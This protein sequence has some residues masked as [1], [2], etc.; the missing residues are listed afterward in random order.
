MKLTDLEETR[1]INMP[2]TSLTDVALSRIGRI[3]E[4]LVLAESCIKARGYDR[5]VEAYMEQTIREAQEIIAYAGSEGAI[6]F[7]SKREQQR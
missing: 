1:T 7:A 5:A 4:N 6:E 2:R 3:R